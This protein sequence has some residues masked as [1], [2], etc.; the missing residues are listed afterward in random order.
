MELFQLN[1]IPEPLEIPGQLA[2]FPEQRTTQEHTTPKKRTY[3]ELM[4]LSLNDPHLVSILICSV[5]LRFDGRL[6]EEWLY[7]VIVAS[8]HVSYFLYADAIGFLQESGAVVEE[9]DGTKQPVYFLTERGR[10]TA[11]K[12]RQYVPKPF[13]DQVMLTALRFVSREKAL[14]DLSIGYESDDEGCALCMTC[15][16]GGHDMFSLRIHAPSE[17]SAQM[18]GERILRNP[19][20]FFGKIIDIAMNNEE[21]TYDLSDN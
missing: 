19:A 21:E 16:D 9:Q 5:L 18:L 8:G 20:G 4:P 2:F 12:L 13:R 14:R 1:E 7:E 17:D 3:P 15:K 10:M 11:Q 6:P